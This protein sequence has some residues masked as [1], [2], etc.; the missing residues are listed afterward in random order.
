MGYTVQEVFEKLKYYGLAEHI[1]VVRRWL[2]NGDLKGTPPLKRREGWR[3]DPEDLNAFIASRAPGLAEIQLFSHTTNVVKES[4]DV[5]KIKREAQEELWWELVQKFIFE[6][7][8]DV[9]QSLVKEL[10]STRPYTE[11]TNPKI[12]QDLYEDVPKGKKLRVYL[13]H[14]AFPFRGE[15]VSFDMKAADIEEEIAG[16]LIDTIW[17]KRRSIR[18]RQK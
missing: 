10:L 15:R 3:I 11:D 12:L 2:R 18:N 9:K 8:V 16:R 1:E 6:S 17:L 13:L 7:H 4:H 14:G 5:Y